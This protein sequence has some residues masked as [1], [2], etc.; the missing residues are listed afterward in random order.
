MIHQIEGN[1]A[2]DLFLKALNY[3]EANGI[4]MNYKKCQVKEVRQMVSTLTDPMNR[5]LHVEGRNS[6][7][8]ATI[9]E[10]LWLLSGSNIVDGFLSKFLRRAKNYSD[11]GYTWTDGYGPRLYKYN[12]LASVVHRI[13]D[14]KYTRQAVLSIF[15]PSVESYQSMI[16]TIGHPNSKD[17]SCNNLMYFTVEDGKLDLHITNRSNDIFF[18]AY[19]INLFSFTLIQEIL[20]NI[21]DLKV[22]KYST[23][24]HN[25]HYYLDNEI[26]VKQRNKILAS[27]HKEDLSTYLPETFTPR[28]ELG[29]LKNEFS[30]DKTILNIRDF[31]QNVILLLD[32]PNT[33]YFELLDYISSK[34]IEIDSKLGVYIRTVYCY[35]NPKIDVNRVFA[36]EG[37]H[38]KLQYAIKNSK[39]N[40]NNREG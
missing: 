21:L 27:D 38:E 1:S 35:L 31:F 29:N 19:T 32:N 14:D 15:D 26:I 36:S 23:Y 17:M 39:F 18:G 25:A 10:T 5:Y 40:P 4:E 8:F 22:G 12:Q 16:N 9:S 34:E 6:N 33:S 28:I 24:Q 20:A 13:K 7:I 11:D 2:S 3:I 30:V 37:C